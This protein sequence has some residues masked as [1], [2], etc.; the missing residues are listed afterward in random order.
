VDWGRAKSVM[1]FSFLMLNL[2]LG[3]QLWMDLRAQL[4]ANVDSAE[5][6]ADKVTLMQQKRITLAANLPVDTPKLGELTYL[7]LSDNIRDKEPTKLEKPVDSAIIFTKSALVAALGDTVPELD[8]YAYDLSS[9]RDGVFVLHRMVDGRPMFNAKLELYVSNLKITAFRQDRVELTG[10]GEPKQVLSAAKVVA[11]L[12]EMYLEPGSV[13]TDIRLGY[14]GQIFD[15][16]KQVAAPS[17]RVMLEDGGVYYV[18]AISGEVATDGN[19]PD[20][21]ELSVSAE[22]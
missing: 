22:K 20:A 4:N 16:E 10:M 1:I 21:E 18:H 14:H 13:I 3:Y 17:W 19:A 2:L 7:L 9:S 8:Q 6:P 11:S 15:S 12:I 5:L